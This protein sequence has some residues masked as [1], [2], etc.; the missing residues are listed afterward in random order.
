MYLVFPNTEITFSDTSNYRPIS[1]T[2]NLCKT[3]DAMINNRL[4]C[5]RQ[6]DYL[7]T[8]LQSDVRKT[9]DT[10]DHLVRFQTHFNQTF[11]KGNMAIGVFLDKETAFDMTHSTWCIA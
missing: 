3:M 2:S 1:L 7:I 5:Y 9:H 8:D 10:V 11:A 4:T 6:S